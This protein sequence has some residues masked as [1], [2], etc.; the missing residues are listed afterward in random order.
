MVIFAS[1]LGLMGSQ[2]WVVFGLQWDG[3]SSVVSM[4][5]SAE[6]LR[7]RPLSLGNT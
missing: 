6:G 2:R 4:G 1:Y 5:G 3:C 7:Y